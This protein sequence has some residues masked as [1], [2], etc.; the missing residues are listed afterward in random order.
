LLRQLG[1][2][3]YS[4]A[5]PNLATSFAYTNAD[6]PIAAAYVPALAFQ[7]NVLGPASSPVILPV[8]DAG[9]LSLGSY[10]VNVP[11]LSP[12]FSNALVVAYGAPTGAYCKPLYWASLPGSS[13][14]TI[15]V[16]CFSAIDLASERLLAGRRE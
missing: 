4:S 11:V 6:N 16:T 2:L 3:N 1:V 14:T 15:R 13:G 12:I 8:L 7:R 10:I 9:R 5:W